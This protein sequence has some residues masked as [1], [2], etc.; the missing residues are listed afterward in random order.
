M[1]KHYLL[2]IEQGENAGGFCS[3]EERKTYFLGSHEE[4]D[5]ILGDADIEPQHA[6]LTVTDDGVCWRS[7][8]GSLT[9]KEQTLNRGNF[10]TWPVNAEIQICSAKIRIEP[11]AKSFTKKHASNDSHTKSASATASLE[12]IPKRSVSLKRKAAISAALFSCVLFASMFIHSQVNLESQSKSADLNLS[13]TL[14]ERISEMLKDIGKSEL[15]LNLENDKAIV[16]GYVNTREDL[17]KLKDRFRLE[18]IAV[19]L[20]V[21]TGEDLS[22]SVQDV[23]RMHGII[24]QTGYEGEGVVKV[25]GLKDSGKKFETAVRASLENVS[26]LK[27]ITLGES[28]FQSA[29]VA[30]KKEE[31]PSSSNS[32]MVLSDA[33]GGPKRV[34]ALVAG[35]SPFVMT[36]DGTRYFEGALLPMGHKLV[37]IRDKEIV[38]ERDGQSQVIAF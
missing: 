36:A 21:L 16:S 12:G 2:I 7:V 35:D 30:T 11:K 23:M 4:C 15:S 25:N 18:Q 38:V 13:K 1:P 19:S 32:P 14:E 26:G 22:A 8:Q 5:I 29:Q 27:R 6:A 37:Q 24:V 3:L 20:Q 28:D 9:Y 17:T 33:S 34:T 31:A 10:A